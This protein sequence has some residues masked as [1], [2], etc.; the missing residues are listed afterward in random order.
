[1]ILTVFS[2]FSVFL[3]QIQYGKISVALPGLVLAASKVAV[4]FLPPLK[5]ACAVK[6]PMGKDTQDQL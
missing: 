2:P 4:K 6:N 5:C 1:L 3:G